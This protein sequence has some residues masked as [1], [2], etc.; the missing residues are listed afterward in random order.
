[1]SASARTANGRGSPTSDNSSGADSP[2]LS[3]TVH[4]AAADPLRAAILVAVILVASLLTQ[5][6]TGSPVLSGFAL[7]ALG[8][9]LRAWFLPRSYEVD[10]VGAREDGPL[11]SRRDLPWAEVRRVAR[12]R[13]GIHLSTLHSNSRFVRD[14]GLFLRTAANRDE[15]ARFV[16]S[17]RATL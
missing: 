8:F 3:W 7:L 2:G 17:A 10:S 11:C 15:V 9:S 16:D 5:A 1:M 4:P 13:F 14:H 12:S 6:V